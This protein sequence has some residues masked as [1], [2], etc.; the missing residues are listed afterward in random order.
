MVI[1]LGGEMGNDPDASDGH[2][3]LN[4]VSS[5]PMG[6]EVGMSVLGMTMAVPIETEMAAI[7]EL[8]DIADGSVVMGGPSASMAG[9]NDMTIGSAYCDM[10][11]VGS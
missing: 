11:N 8:G 2:D 7:S 6:V 9:G 10:T 3:S 1:A 4:L 5:I